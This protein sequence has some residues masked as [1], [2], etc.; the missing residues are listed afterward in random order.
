VEVFVQRLKATHK[1]TRF[2]KSHK[3]EVLEKIFR[4]K[5]NI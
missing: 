5:E 3:I 4:K 2:D 1:P